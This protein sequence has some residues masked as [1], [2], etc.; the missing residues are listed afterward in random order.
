[1]AINPVPAI[2]PTSVTAS[3]SHLRVPVVID[4]ASQQPESKADREAGL[5][6]RTGPA[7]PR[8]E[9]KLISLWPSHTVGGVRYYAQIQHLTFTATRSRIDE[10]V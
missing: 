2:F 7:G 9:D 8:P 5:P 6:A 1:M 4:I 3:A 10:M